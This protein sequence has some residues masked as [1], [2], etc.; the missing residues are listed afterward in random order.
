[1]YTDADGETV[2]VPLV[3][4]PDFDSA[5]E[6]AAAA[7]V[8]VVG[9]VREVFTSAGDVH[10]PLHPDAPEWAPSAGT[11]IE[12]DWPHTGYEI[13]VSAVIEGDAPGAITVLMPQLPREYE[14]EVPGGHVTTSFPAE[15]ELAPGSE[16]ALFLRE[17]AGTYRLVNLDQGVLALGPDGPEPVARSVAP[18]GDVDDEDPG[19][20]WAPTP[21]FLAEVQDMLN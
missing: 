5:A 9:T 1:M 8:V 13:D 20:Y 10:A 19:Q 21:A 14:Q 4:Y 12:E 16:F 7:E 11:L 3:V 2:A 18:T 17:D 15:P 6:M